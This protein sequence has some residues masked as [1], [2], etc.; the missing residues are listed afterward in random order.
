MYGSLS[1]F[2]YNSSQILTWPVLD[3]GNVFE[4]A[5]LYRLLVIIKKIVAY[6]EGWAPHL[7]LVKA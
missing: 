4:E 7:A 1:W 3:L 5:T 2:V 6:L